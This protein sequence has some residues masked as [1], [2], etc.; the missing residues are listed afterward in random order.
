M[1]SSSVGDVLAIGRGPLLY[2]KEIVNRTQLA[3]GTV[4]SKYHA[5]TMPCV[6]KLGRRLVAWEAD[7]EAWLA[8]EQERTTKRPG[9]A[10]LGPYEALVTECPDLDALRRLVIREEAI[11]GTMAE[12]GEDRQTIVDMIGAADSMDQEAVLALTDGAPTTLRAALQAYLD[13][14]GQ[15]AERGETRDAGDVF[16][17]ITALLA[18]PY[19][20]G[21]T[22]ETDLDPE[23][24]EA[25]AIMVNGRVVYRANHDEHGHAGMDAAKS[26]AEAVFRAVAE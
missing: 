20:G 8:F 17:D 14:V 24:D 18:Y 10:R 25:L 15:A 11:R 6:W 9:Q 13:A 2:L 22:L 4:R 5:G 26:A 23:D 7:L 21:A 1:V 19:P 12:T 3:E 16:N